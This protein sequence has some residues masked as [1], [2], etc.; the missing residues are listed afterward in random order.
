MTEKTAPEKNK[1]CWKNIGPGVITGASDDDPSGIATYSQAG[2]VFGLSFLWTALISYPLMYSIQEMSAR[3]GITN[4]S[5]I[6]GVL[7]KYYPPFLTWI[8]LAF[9]SPAIIF[10]IAADLASMGAILNLLFP[11]VTA[12]LWSV[13]VVII[14]LCY[15]FFC[16]YKTIASVFKFCCLALLCYFIVPFLVKQEWSSILYATFIP[17]VEWSREYLILLIAILGTTI[18]PYLFFWQSSMSHEEKQQNSSTNAE[19]IKW[20]KTDVNLGMFASNLAMFFIILTTS[21]VLH[22]N[23]ILKINTVEEAAMALKP[24]AG[25]MAFF[26]FAI[27]I[28][29]VGFLAIP[30]L[31]GC[32]GYMFAECFLWNSGL[33]Y[34]PKQAAPFYGIITTALFSALVIN[35]IGIDPIQS[36]V[37]SAVLYGLIAPPI[38]A[39]ILHICNNPKIMG[40][41]VNSPII[42]VLGALTLILMSAA[43][44]G[45][46]F[47]EIQDWMG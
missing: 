46:V 12:F 41:Y 44:L 45:L 20:M 7:H 35:F 19:E 38:I 37:L 8:A 21:T 10:N 17:Q 5:G 43:I 40:E 31:S 29:G 4:S 24:L 18:S 27:G 11:F 3:I 32:V 28:L 6:I 23:G 16:R 25:E 15:I 13:A 34:T 26:V 42:N 33:D 9:I 2:A 1:K 36:L 22:S 47:F 39:F 30:V 14:S